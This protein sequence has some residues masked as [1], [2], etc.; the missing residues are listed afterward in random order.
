ALA[1]QLHPMVFLF[2]KELLEVF[3]NSV[4]ARK[5]IALWLAGM[6]PGRHEALQSLEE[7]RVLVFPS[8]EKAIRALSA[9]YRLSGPIQKTSC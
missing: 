8:P 1:I 5:P 2:P 4:A 9:L 6:E 7:R 3:G